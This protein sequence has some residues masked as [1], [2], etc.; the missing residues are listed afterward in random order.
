MNRRVILFLFVGF[1]ALD[2]AVLGLYW[3]MQR[4]FSRAQPAP[5]S[6]T[7]NATQ[8]ESAN[9]LVKQGFA[10]R[11]QRQLPEAVAA[12]EE[13]IRQQPEHSDAHH[14]LAQVQREMGDLTGALS[15]H[16]RAITLDPGRHD[17]YWERGVTCQQMKDY[18]AAVR[19]YEAC[20]ER[21]PGFASAHLGLGEAYRALGDLTNSLDHL[22][23][24]IALK[25]D[26]A[27]FHR[28]R[29]NTYRML[30]NEPLAEADFAKVRDLQQNQK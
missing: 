10:Y 17:L 1:I 11:R 2:M 6:A 15:N 5:I 7:A 29:G 21:K 18:S 13:A 3:L 8:T 19:N 14:G 16:D 22:N 25:P 4:H 30:G 28:E 24:A 26:S 23:Q 20:L 27:W 12:F 9:Q